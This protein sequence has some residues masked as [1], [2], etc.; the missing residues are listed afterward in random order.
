MALVF[1]SVA[2]AIGGTPLVRLR[3][4]GRGIAAGFGHGGPTEGRERHRLLE[5]G[6]HLHAEVRRRGGL[7]PRRR[8]PC[9]RSG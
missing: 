4:L 7:R 3:G 5:R 9:G 2:S 6:E 8:P 1:E